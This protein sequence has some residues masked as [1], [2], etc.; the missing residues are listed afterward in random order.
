MWGPKQKLEEQFLGCSIFPLVNFQKKKA[1]FINLL[2]ANWYIS[3]CRNGPH[4]IP[5]K[6][7]RCLVDSMYVLRVFCVRLQWYSWL[8]PKSPWPPLDTP[9]GRLYEQKLANLQTHLY[10]IN[11]TWMVF[12]LFVANS[13][14]NG[15]KNL[16]LQ[17]LEN[18]FIFLKI[19]KFTKNHQIGS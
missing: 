1:N 6:T 3:F 9:L 14:Q 7:W 2:L 17:N 10:K 12:F 8:L 18:K 5:L 16:Q 15:T 19:T 13:F 4:F 11:I